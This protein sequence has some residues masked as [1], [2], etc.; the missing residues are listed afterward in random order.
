LLGDA[1]KVVIAEH[2]HG[3]DEEDQRDGQ[4]AIGEPQDP[5]NAECGVV[6]ACQCI[7]TAVRFSPSG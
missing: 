3:G 6:Q 4:D 5:S 2:D 1:R 7:L